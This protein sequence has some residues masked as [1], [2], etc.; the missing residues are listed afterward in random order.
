[1]K[2]RELKNEFRKITWPGPREV[3]KKTGV[4]LVLCVIMALILSLFDLFFN[5]IIRGLE[6]MFLKG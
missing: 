1:M 4:S 2:F 5:W 6:D 3:A